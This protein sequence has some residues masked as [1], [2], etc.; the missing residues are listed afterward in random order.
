MNA[1]L[2][3][4]LLL[5]MLAALN[6]CALLREPEDETKNWSAREIQNAAK[7]ALN[8][9]DYETSIKY[10]EILDARYPLGIFA[11]QAQ[12]DV[13]YAYYKSEEPESAIAA[14]DRF[15]KLYPRHPHVDYA[16]YMKGLANFNQR[17]G[18]L[19]R[20][21]PLDLSERDQAASK[22]SFQNFAELLTL[23]PKSMYADDARQRMV[24]LRNSLARY[25]L[26]AA[27][28]YLR[29]GAYLAAVNRAQ[30]VVQHYDRTTPVPDA[31]LIMAKAYKHLGYADL[32]KDTLSVL[33]LNYPDYPYLSELD[34]IKALETELA[35]LKPR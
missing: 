30:Y 14:A 18:M 10:Y 4:L 23:Y 7:A 25:E 20:Y 22:Q 2:K 12:L 15:I 6:G 3:T 1:V 33:T 27:D 17:F 29:R 5:A 26:H 24:Y 21:L 13:I 32:L 35:E 28:Y 19:E 8:G 34:D 31:L 16:Y 11:Q 9:G